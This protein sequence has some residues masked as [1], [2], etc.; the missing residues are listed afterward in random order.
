MVSVCLG[1]F[2][3]LN[4]LR[5]PLDVKSAGAQMQNELGQ[6]VKVTDIL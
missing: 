6:L 4:S 2:V 5:C 1:E 3:S